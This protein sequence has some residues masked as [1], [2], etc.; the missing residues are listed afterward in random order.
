MPQYVCENKG[1]IWLYYSGWNRRVE[2][3][4]SNWTGLAVSED[5]GFTFKRMFPGPIIDR[6]PEE[7]FSATGA[8]VVREN[9][10]WHMWY[11]SGVDW[12][13]INEKLEEYYVIKHASSNDGI[14]WNRDNSK[15]LPSKKDFEPTHRPSVIKLGEAYHMW[16]CYRGLEDFRDGG[17]SY[18]IGYA[19]SRDMKT[20]ERDDEKAG[21]DVSKE[22]WDSRMIAYPYVV[23]T[24]NHT[25]MFYNGNGFGAS[26]FGY[27]VLDQSDC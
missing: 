20:W 25:Y 11:A 7:V 14:N 4:Y 24:K 5:G 8:Y 19:G 3:P 12:I 27:A 10:T 17:N 21:I 6:T 18:R 1:Q 15:L 13:E 16:F 23:E 9:G 2:V 26:G 22:G